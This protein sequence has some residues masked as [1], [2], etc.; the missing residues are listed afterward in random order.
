MIHMT[1]FSSIFIIAASLIY[2]LS[3]FLLKGSEK[4]NISRMPGI[5]FY[6]HGKYKKTEWLFV[7]IA[8]LSAGAG[9]LGWMFILDSAGNF[10]VQ[11]LDHQIIYL[12]DTGRLSGIQIILGIITGLFMTMSFFKIKLGRFF[13]EFLM[14]A[15]DKLGFNNLKVL[16]RSAYFMLLVSFIWT[17]FTVN[18]YMIVDAD[19]IRLKN[20]GQFSSSYYNF[21]EVRA[22]SVTE[23][24]QPRQSRI[25][26]SILVR[27]SFNDGRTWSNFETPFYP[28]YQNDRRL[29]QEL[30]RRT[31]IPMQPLVLSGTETTAFSSF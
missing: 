21:D 30:G 2:A 27:L 13:E 11:S 22:I 5:S 12:A 15:N 23:L 20:W 8:L 14:Y 29:L 24:S 4:A 25:K 19:Q 1:I 9:F 17:M 7:V 26:K 10:I 18:T 16:G 31:K 3:R 6:L 28:Q